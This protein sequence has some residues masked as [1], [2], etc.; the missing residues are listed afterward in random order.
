[1][2]SRYDNRLPKTLTNEKYREAFEK[3]GVS[4]IDIYPT[5]ILNFPTPEQI[6]T[7]VIERHIWTDGDRLWKLAAKFYNNP[8]LWWVLAWMNKKPTEAHFSI[9]EIVYIPTPL[10]KVLEYLGV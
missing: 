8:K 3:R 5:P 10:E 1:M 6:S 4:F 7:L 2:T 9:G